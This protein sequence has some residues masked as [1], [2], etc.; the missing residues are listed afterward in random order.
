MDNFVLEI[1]NALPKHLC[2]E[3]I[4]RFESDERKV[5]GVVSYGMISDKPFED[6]ELKKSVE[7]FISVCDDW[8]DIDKSISECISKCIRT[9][10]NYIKSNFDDWNAKLNPLQSF[11]NMTVVDSGYQIQKTPKGGKYAWH[12]DGGI[13]NNDIAS[14]IIYLNTLDYGEGGCTKFTNGRKVRPETGKMLI[15]PRTWT[16]IHSGEEVKSDKHKYTCIARISLKS[17]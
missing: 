2:E 16:F 11:V 17:A 1:P 14:V 10:F 7:L 13:G 8:G 3:M 15:F 12:Y 6:P 9:Y 5:S 4:K